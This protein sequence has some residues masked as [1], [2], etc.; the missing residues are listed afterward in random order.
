MQSE[1]IVDIFWIIMVEYSIVC[2][3]KTLLLFLL[4]FYG[5]FPF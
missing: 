1:T 2:I 4:L 3:I 5:Y